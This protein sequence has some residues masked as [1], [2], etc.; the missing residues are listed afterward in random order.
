[1][2]EATE[3]FEEAQLQPPADEDRSSFRGLPK[4][5]YDQPAIYRRQPRG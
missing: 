1:M 2:R 4:M 5:N 3:E